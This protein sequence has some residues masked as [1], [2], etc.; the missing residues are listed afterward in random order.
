MG[1]CITLQLLTSFYLLGPKMLSV[2]DLFVEV[3]F[4]F[5]TLK[6]IKKDVRARDDAVVI[7]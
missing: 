2:H 6:C 7:M 4:E 5:A 3:K 1:Q